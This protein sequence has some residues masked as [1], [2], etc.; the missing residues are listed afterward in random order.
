VIDGWAGKGEADS[1]PNVLAAKQ[2]LQLL[3]TQDNFRRASEKAGS[4]AVNTSVEALRDLL[5]AG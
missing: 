4:A 1:D 5:K 2:T 3:I